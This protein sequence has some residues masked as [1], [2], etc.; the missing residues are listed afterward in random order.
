MRRL[1]AIALPAALL[2]GL[3][4]CASAKGILGAEVCGSNG[5]RAIHAT[6]NGVL[7]GG[8]RTSGPSRAEPFVRLHVRVGVPGHSQRMSVLFLPR[9]ELLLASDGVTW[10]V[11]LALSELRAIARR[12]RPFAASELPA[13]ALSATAGIGATAPGGAA[14]RSGGGFETWWLA[15][16]GAA[17]VLAAGLAITRRRRREPH[18]APARAIG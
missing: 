8:P 16:P 4:P 2:L 13:S 6:E 3:P 11:P 7:G 18:P 14:T 15:L 1:I 5:C 12:V 17:I 10:M 9:S